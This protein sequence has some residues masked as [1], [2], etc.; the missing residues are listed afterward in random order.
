MPLTGYN[1]CLDLEAIQT[2]TGNTTTLSWKLWHYNKESTF[3]AACCWGKKMTRDRWHG[4]FQ[5]LSRHHQSWEGSQCWR[6]C[7]GASR[8]WHQLREKHIT[9][10]ERCFVQPFWHLDNPATL[11]QVR[12]MVLL[13]CNANIATATHS[14]VQLLESPPFKSSWWTVI[15]FQIWKWKCTIRFRIHYN[16]GTCLGLF[17][18]S[19]LCWNCGHRKD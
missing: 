6:S 12:L 5:W 7:W 8:V 17:S 13:K 11:P 2:P 9:S 15:I 3:L 16:A 14:G 4:S 18:G 10:D 19:Q 1:H